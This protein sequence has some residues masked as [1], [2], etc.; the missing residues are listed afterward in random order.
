MRQGTTILVR[1]A[2]EE[3]EGS[4]NDIILGW[5]NRS[6]MAWNVSLTKKHMFGTRSFGYMALCAIFEVIKALEKLEGL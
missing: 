4:R 1:R 6:W 2:L 5:A 3:L